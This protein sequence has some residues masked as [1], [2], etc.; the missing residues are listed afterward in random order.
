MTTRDVTVVQED[1]NVYLKYLPPHLHSAYMEGLA[2]PQ[3]TSLRRQIALNETRIKTLLLNLDQEVLDEAEIEA[4]LRT[5]FP[6]LDPSLYPRLAAF[7]ASFLPE[8]FIDH[9]TFKRLEVLVNKYETAML[10]RRVRESDTVLKELFETIRK[11]RASGSIW[12]EISQS[13]EQQRKLAEAEE[14]RSNQMQQVMT[15]DKVVMLLGFT[16]QALKEAV[17][18]YVQDTEI[19]GYILE[20]TERIYAAQFT[21][22]E[23]TR[24]D[25]IAVDK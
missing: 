6:K 2:D 9:R 18:L 23:H 1:A 17:S 24:Q 14:H 10:H 7:V 21:P 12:E 22:G 19:R 13:L 20:H 15:L 11:G 4:Q 5:Q 8:N 3:I 16:I 25:Q